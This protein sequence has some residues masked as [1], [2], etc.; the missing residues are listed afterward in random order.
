MCN[1]VGGMW[2]KFNQFQFNQIPTLLLG[3]QIESTVVQL[4]VVVSIGN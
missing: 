2:A 3:K 1:K 4:K